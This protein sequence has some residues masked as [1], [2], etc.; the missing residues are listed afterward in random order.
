MARRW[1]SYFWA[2]DREWIAGLL[3]PSRHAES[4]QVGLM[5]LGL[6]AL[7]GSF[8]QLAAVLPILFG[9]LWSEVMVERRWRTSGQSERMTPPLPSRRSVA[10]VVIATGLIGLSGGV[11]DGFRWVDVPTDGPADGQVALIQGLIGAELAVLALCTTGIALAIQVRAAHYGLATAL[12]LLA[13]V[14]F[15]IALVPLLLSSVLGI[16]LLGRWDS[17]AAERE[18]LF[19]SV[20]VHLGLLG[21]LGMGH[22]AVTGVQRQTDPDCL[23]RELERCIRDKS[24]AQSVRVYGWNVHRRRFSYVT[25][26]QLP[27]TARMMVRAL[28]GALRDSDLELLSN[29]AMVWHDAMDDL[30]EVREASQ[31]PKPGAPPLSWEAADFLNGLDGIVADIVTDFAA[32]GADAVHIES[33]APT[34]WA[35]TPPFTPHRGHHEHRVLDP[36]PLPGFRALVAFSRATVQRSDPPAL[37]WLVRNLWRRQLE[38]TILRVEAMAVAKSPANRMLELDAI[39]EAL[40]LVSRVATQTRTLHESIVSEVSGAVLSSASACQTDDAMDLCLSA[41]HG[42]DPYSQREWAWQWHELAQLAG[43][44]RL[45]VGWHVLLF[46]TSVDRFTKRGEAIEYHELSDLIEWLVALSVPL[47]AVQ[48]D[49]QIGR[50]LR[51]EWT[52]SVANSVL[53]AITF[54]LVA[55]RRD[56][57]GRMRFRLAEF[58]RD[59]FQR[60]PSRLQDEIVER[61]WDWSYENEPLSDRW[62]ARQVERGYLVRVRAEQN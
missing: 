17:L 13:P 52:K 6:A 2:S 58:F 33:I 61:A 53:K 19:P 43:K 40:R 30:P 4:I 45:S 12:S 48:K 5:L 18:S 32:A 23:L 22:A 60:L 28:H 35:I 55:P 24:W 39:G 25:S 3:S 36:E 38:L 20:V 46:E 11:A 16:L 62:F 26:A 51:A 14:R 47:D 37:E 1:G 29:L 59:E 27:A 44:T 21:I 41:L 9:L 57:D 56:G 8:Y 34:L 50:D 10:W 49:E 42:L 7:G 31:N 54:A 15:A